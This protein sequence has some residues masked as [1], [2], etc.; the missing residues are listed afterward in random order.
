[1]KIG[2]KLGDD[3]K[4]DTRKEVRSLQGYKNRQYMQILKDKDVLSKIVFQSEKGTT[5]I[6]Q[7]QKK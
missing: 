3:G 1:L 6:I 4:P 5:Q 2:V 7:N